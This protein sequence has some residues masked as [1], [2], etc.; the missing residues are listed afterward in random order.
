MR[1]GGLRG[2]CEVSVQ[3]RDHLRAFADGRGDP[4]GRAGANIAD[5]VDAGPAGFE[6]AAMLG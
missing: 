2:R 4:F 3:G 6:G 1:C 5:S